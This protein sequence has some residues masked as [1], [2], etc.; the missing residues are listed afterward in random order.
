MLREVDFSAIL[1]AGI[2]MMTTGNEE[3]TPGNPH[4][5][6]LYFHYELQY[7]QI[8][9]QLKCHLSSEMSHRKLGNP[10]PGSREN[11]TGAESSPSQRGSN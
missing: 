1:L 10:R 8:L 3:A 2:K 11:G 7:Y 6:A 9:W 4:E 5:F